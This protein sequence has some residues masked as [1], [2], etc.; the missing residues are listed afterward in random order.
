MLISSFGPDRVPKDWKPALFWLGIA[1]VVFAFAWPAI[2]RGWQRIKKG[3]PNPFQRRGGS[4]YTGRVHLS[5][6]ELDTKGFFDLSVSAFNGTPYSFQT[7][8]IEGSVQID[9]PPIGGGSGSPGF[10]VRAPVL[11]GESP[12]PHRPDREFSINTRLFLDASQ[13][14]EIRKRQASGHQIQFMLG[15]LKVELETKNGKRMRLPLWDGA[16]LSGSQIAVGRIQAIGLTGA[17]VS[18]ESAGL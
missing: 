6:S 7:T 2:E 12:K 16:S 14:A 5:D 9:S 8:S 18:V 17:S 10:S 3:V 13:V 1:L 4:L 11:Y 15:G